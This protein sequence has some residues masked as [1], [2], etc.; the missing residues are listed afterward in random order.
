M[1]QVNS[2]NHFDT[3]QTL[4]K[5]LLSLKHCAICYEQVIVQT[6]IVKTLAEVERPTQP[7][8]DIHSYW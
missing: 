7:Y 2:V 6:F 8:C 3:V 1:L 5:Y 4:E